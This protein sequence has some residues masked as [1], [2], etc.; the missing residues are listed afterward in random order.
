MFIFDIDDTLEESRR[1]R[2]ESEELRR[3]ARATVQAVAVVRET[4]KMQR[5]S[6][7]L[8]LPPQEIEVE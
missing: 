5:E 8:E 7:N 4:C 6:L 2:A 1:L 3:R